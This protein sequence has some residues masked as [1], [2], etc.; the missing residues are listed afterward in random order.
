MASNAENPEARRQSTEDQVQLSSPGAPT[1]LS[2]ATALSQSSNDS[3][4]GGMSAM[5]SAT[6][7]AQYSSATSGASGPVDASGRSQF[8][9]FELAIVMSHW[10]VGVIQKVQEFPRGSRKA[11]KLVLKTDT[12]NYLLKRR[13]RGKDDPYKVAFC[14]SLQFHLADRQ[15]PLPHLIGTKDNNNSML[16]LNNRLYELFEYI[17]G[18]SYD[19]SLEA[20]SDAGK[21]LAL[22]HKLLK[23]FKSDYETPKG[24]YH[25][26]RPVYAALKAIP[27]TMQKHSTNAAELP[28]I[29]ELAKFLYES[30][31]AAAQKV[32]ELGL[33]DWPKQII[34]SDWHS[35]NLLFRGQRVVAVIDYDAARIQ[36]R[37]ID[38]A[39]GALQ[40]SVIGGGEEP[41]TWPEYLDES[42]FKRFLRAYESVPDCMLSVA[43]IE[44]IPW[45]M[46]EA[47]IA[48]A[49][50]PIAATGSFGR[51]RG[52]GMMEM[53][54]RKVKWLQ[55]QAAKLVDAV[56]S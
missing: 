13:A 27:N 56:E 16:Q 39:N 30:Y 44:T 10:D 5:S 33:P 31:T 12:G 11:P 51:L 20:T 45:L 21:I 36:P 35:G 37:M 49:A 54:F 38:V 19:L 28:R 42:R 18:I 17:K 22:F 8:T 7:S 34:H 50:I 14:H 55:N 26:A 52:L 29:N 41:E 2:G 40:F 3:S 32:D 47:L 46:I 9:A 4:M 23:D 15:F 24:S 1:P 25:Q 6:S 53:I 48:E 43:E